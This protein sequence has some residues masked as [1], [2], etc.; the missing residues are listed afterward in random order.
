[1]ALSAVALAILATLSIWLVSTSSDNTGQNKTTNQTGDNSNTQSKNASNSASS[2]I[3]YTLPSGWTDTECIGDT[4]TILIIPLGKQKPL[5]CASGVK[6]WPIKIYID[7]GNT[8]DCGQFKFDQQQITGHVCKSV[9]IDGHKTI[10]AATKYNEKSSYGK[11]TDVLAYYI[12]TASKVVKLEYTD[13]VA[14]RGDDFLGG[15]EELVA[16]VKVK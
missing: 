15:F 12:N 1:M 10:R 14:D 6:D 9:F 5:D 7:P 2:L 3:S 11:L 8:T 13:N 4:N 16:S